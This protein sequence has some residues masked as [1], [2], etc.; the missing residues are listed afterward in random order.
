MDRKLKIV[1]GRVKY[2][3]KTFDGSIVSGTLSATEAGA[4]AAGAKVDGSIIG[5]ELV[6]NGL[7]LETESVKVE[8]SEMSA[9]EEKPTKRGKRK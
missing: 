6:N 4:I 1:D 8:V 5:F 2:I 9:S 3:K 7:H